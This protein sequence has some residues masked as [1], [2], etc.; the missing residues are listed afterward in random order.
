MPG[1]STRKVTYVSAQGNNTRIEIY[2]LLTDGS[3]ALTDTADY[4]FD[5]ENRWIKRTRGN[6]RV[7]EREMMCCGPLWE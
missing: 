3:W 7:T 4:E 1:H 5:R 2:A 6:G